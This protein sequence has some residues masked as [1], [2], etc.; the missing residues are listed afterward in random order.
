MFRHLSRPRQLAGPALALGLGTLIW[1]PAGRAVAY[2]TTGSALGL[3]QRHFRVLDNFS[4]PSANDNLTPHPNFPGFQG[5][6][7]A[8]WKGCLE[9]GSTRHGDGLGDPHQ[10]FSG[11]GSGGADFDPA[12]QGLAT[13]VGAVDS[14][15]HSELAGSGAGVLAYCETAPGG[16][17]RIRYY[18][19]IAWEDGP[20][21][22]VAF[23]ESDLQGV[24]CH[25]YGHA[26]GLGHS[27]TFG[28][29][30]YP[31]INGTGVD[32]RSIAGDDQMGLQSLYGALT[33]TKPRIEG[34]EVH[35]GELWIQGAH[36]AP[37]GVEV[38]FTPAAAGGGGVPVKAQG[39]GSASGDL[40]RVTV[41]PGAGPGD[42]LVRNPGDGHASLSN[43][44]PSDLVATCPAPL[45]WGPTSPNSAGSGA[46]IDAGGSASVA[47]ADMTL[48]V[49]GCP[50]G[51]FG[52]FFYG[53]EAADQPLG[54]GR[55]LVGGESAGL[56]RLPALQT[57]GVGAATQGVPF[58]APQQ[59]FGPAA[60]VA[61]S[62]WNFQFWYRDPA[63]GGAGF[64]LSNGLLV[65][66]CD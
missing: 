63:A 52:L 2:S 23:G 25:E 26:L 48:S 62:S 16:G 24:A 56:L 4:D 11:I 66:F 28:A 7:V 49:I 3:D 45:A 42:V 60:L 53:S 30:M 15:T 35:A 43:A 18:S 1:L 10:L 22:G 39:L 59:S 19:D 8:I 58:A 12:F 13:G 14:N 38:W 50:A 40:L 47:A 64:N 31:S 17:W 6:A 57:D 46:L 34:L 44:W 51:A 32:Q 20:D 37:S 21:T 5:A 33:S 36:F 29:T 54:D 65:G 9:W 61:G 55:L 27:S 41:P